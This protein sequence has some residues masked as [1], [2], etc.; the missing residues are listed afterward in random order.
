MIINK[1]LYCLIGYPV[2]HSLSPTIHNSAFR[3]SCVEAV[4]TTMLVKP[5]DLVN[6]ISMLRKLDAK[7]INVTMPHKERVTRFIDEIDETAK[8][9]RAVN[10]IVNKEGRL[11]GYNTD[12]SGAVDAVKSVMDELNGKR[13]IILGRGGMGRATAFG[14][15]QEGMTTQLLGRDEMEE[16]S[17]SSA[18]SDAD[19]VCNCTPLGMSQGSTPIPKKLLR[20]ELVVFDAVYVNGRTNLIR[21]AQRK[22]CKTI[23]GIQMLVNQ[24]ANSFKLWTGKYPNRE[25]ML[26]AAR[27]RMEEN[28]RGGRKNIYFVGFSGSGKSNVGERVARKLRRKFVDIDEEIS[29][30]YAQP[31]KDIFVSFGEGEFRKMEHREIGKVSERN[32]LVI[33]PG[34][35][36]VLIYENISRMKDSGT[37]I[38]LRAEPSTVYERL[39]GDGSRPLLAGADGA[40]ELSKILREMNLRMPYYELARDLE[41]ITDG[42]SVDTVAKEAIGKLGDFE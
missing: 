3:D 32:G 41:T 27:K 37:I 20:K 22:G 8:E 39:K 19:L 14:L 21:D 1:D 7:G 36:S 35:G 42:K 28:K 9:I 6:S 25:V 31:I 17:L 13:A 18:I 33:A 26:N 40:V 4:Y 34:G 2:S 16:K 12:A 30:S 15:G 23:D 38:F 10:T 11:K 29:A 24:G 5:D